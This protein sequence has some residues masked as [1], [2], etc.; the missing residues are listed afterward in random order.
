MSSA[1]ETLPDREAETLVKM[2]KEI[3]DVPNDKGDDYA[4]GAFI[5]QVLVRLRARALFFFVSV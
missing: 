3:V 5:Q 4:D 1:S 2:L